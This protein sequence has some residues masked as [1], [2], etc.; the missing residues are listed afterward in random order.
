MNSYICTHFTLH[1]GYIDHALYY[2]SYYTATFITLYLETCDHGIPDR[3]LNN[4]CSSNSSSVE[5][6]ILAPV[7]DKPGGRKKNQ[8]LAINAVI[9]YPSDN[10]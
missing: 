6:S 2:Y 10:K 4:R 5:E 9:S 1:L 8:S 7:S 3:D